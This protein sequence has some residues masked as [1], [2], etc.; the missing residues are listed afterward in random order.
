MVSLPW[1][2][3]P[4]HDLSGYWILIYTEPSTQDFTM[5][6]EARNTERY[7][8]GWRS[9]G[10]LRKLPVNFVRS[11]PPKN[12]EQQN[13]KPNDTRLPKNGQFPSI[14]TAETDVPSFATKKNGAIDPSSVSTPSPTP[15]QQPKES[16]ARNYN[17]M[18]DGIQSLVLDTTDKGSDRALKDFNGVKEAYRNPES[19][20]SSDSE[21][22]VL[23]N[24][25]GRQPRQLLK[26]SQGSLSKQKSQNKTDISIRQDSVQLPASNL[27][28]TSS[29]GRRGDTS[30]A[31]PPTSSLQTAQPDLALERELESDDVQCVSSYLK[32]IAHFKRGSKEEENAVLQD[33]IDNVCLA[34]DSELGGNRGGVDE[35][36]KESELSWDSDDLKDLDNLSTSDEEPPK[37]VKRILSKRIRGSGLQYLVHAERQSID[38]ARWIP[39][40]RL[41][42]VDK[43]IGAFEARYAKKISQVAIP[44]STEGATSEANE[45]TDDLLDEIASE[46]DEREAVR[47]ITTMKT[48]QQI[49]HALSRQEMFSLPGDE[50]FLLDGTFN[51]DNT[52]DE[53]MDL[54]DEEDSLFRQHR[55]YNQDS[56]SRGTRKSRRRDGFPSAS[57]FADALDQDPYGAFDVMDFERPSLKPKSKGGR[58]RVNSEVLEDDEL[59]V[60]L[61]QSWETDRQKKKLRKLERQKL[62]EQGELGQK[63]DRID[64]KAKYPHGIKHPQIKAEVKGFML[65]PSSRLVCHYL[66]GVSWC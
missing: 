11:G 5:A 55:N 33:Y 18:S 24:G 26:K 8:T 57:A 43:Q 4:S 25:R 65:S 2:A 21:D 29:S 6:Q 50:V 47:K 40:S 1:F 20:N 45:A 51:G 49:A 10:Q 53:T 48:D 38:D 17:V 54:A 63:K 46:E 61:Q 34:D 37:K 15:D 58:A 52:S 30:N 28:G 23:F 44:D 19:Q 27:L 12:N 16:G 56:P 35:A 36:N 31:Y 59:A 62:R 14:R 41:G 3:Y 32:R 39:S 7:G 60:R 64:M 42:H 22:I 66:D 9:Q 13:S